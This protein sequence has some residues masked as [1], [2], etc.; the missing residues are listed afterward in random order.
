MRANHDPKWTRMTQAKRS[1]ARRPFSV[2]GDSG[3]ILTYFWI[4][5]TKWMYL[6]IYVY[7]HCVHAN[8]SPTKSLCPICVYLESYPDCSKSV[9]TLTHSVLGWKLEGVQTPRHGRTSE[10]GRLGGA[11]RRQFQSYY[12]MTLYQCRVRL[13]YNDPV[14][15]ALDWD[16]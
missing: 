15:A 13:L 2:G 14:H 6:V 1:G 12:V 10:A 11:S 16:S 4:A 5:L 7:N 3:R 8:S 9:L